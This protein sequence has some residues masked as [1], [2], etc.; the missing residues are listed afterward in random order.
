MFMEKDQAYN[1]RDCLT[2]VQPKRNITTFGLR[3][4]SYFG[5]K[6]FNELPNYMKDVNQL[7]LDT[8]KMLLRTWKG[9]AYYNGENFYI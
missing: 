2:L 7:D 1:M 6:L 4:F 3:S 5:S 9:P 8:F